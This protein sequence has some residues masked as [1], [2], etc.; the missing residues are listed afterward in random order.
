[1]MQSTVGFIG[2]YEG[3]IFI[4]Y[5]LFNFSIFLDAIKGFSIPVSV[6]LIFIVLASTMAILNLFID[7]IG[8]STHSKRNDYGKLLRHKGAK[9]YGLV[10][11]LIEFAAALASI[12]L[13]F[14]NKEDIGIYLYLLAIVSLIQTIISVVRLARLGSKVYNKTTPKKIKKTKKIIVDNRLVFNDE[15]LHGDYYEE[16][17]VVSPLYQGATVAAAGNTNYVPVNK[18]YE[19]FRD[20]VQV[21][22]D[23]YNDYYAGA[24]QNGNGQ[25]GGTYPQTNG[26]NNDQTR[27]I[28]YTA[29]TIYNGPRDRFIDGLTDEQKVE[30]CKVFLEKSMGTLP[31]IPSYVVNGDNIE[32][33]RSVFSRLNTFKGIISEGLLDK[34]YQEIITTK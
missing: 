4:T 8:L 29:R 10:R 22:H 13:A 17:E 14:A 3:Y 9:V 34:I 1:M 23:I 7:I 6:E 30:F 26:E 32:F 12:I 5:Y 20:I 27:T 2:L 16:I 31:E 15:L 18:N 19:G 11:Y 21:P 28:I 24:P 25:N 33:F